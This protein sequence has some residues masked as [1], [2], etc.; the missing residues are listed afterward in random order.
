MNLAAA[1]AELK[2]RAAAYVRTTDGNHLATH[3]ARTVKRKH[4]L[5]GFLECAE[6]GGAF[7]ALY[8]PSQ[9]RRSV[10]TSGDSGVPL[11]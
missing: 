2:R 8:P 6:C 11:I 1:Q 5:A 7:Y 10:I 3:T 4:L 9:A